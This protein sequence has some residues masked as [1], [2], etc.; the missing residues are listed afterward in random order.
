MVVVRR[1]GR[2]SP[3]T[4]PAL[5]A[6]R[7]PRAEGGRAGV[8]DGRYKAALMRPPTANNPHNNIYYSSAFYSPFARSRPRPF[9]KYSAPRLCAHPSASR[10][11]RRWVVQRLPRHDQRPSACP[12]LA[13]PTLNVA[14]FG[15]LQ[16]RI[17]GSF[18]RGEG[19]AR[20]TR[21]APLRAFGLPA[22]SFSLVG[23]RERRSLRRCLTGEW[24]MPA[25]ARRG[26]PTADCAQCALIARLASVS[27][28]IALPP[29]VLTGADPPPA[30]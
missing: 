22:G 28:Q 12:F 11:D 18:G 14:D 17:I 30:A 29:P 1:G 9:A 19:V 6:L 23:Y 10:D 27:G 13:A 25:A 7:A 4:L 15:S 8:N 3:T 5:S 2:R 24:E 21:S 16:G 20:T 26:H